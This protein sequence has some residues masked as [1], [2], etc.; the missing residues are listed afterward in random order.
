MDSDAFE[1][2]GSTSP[3]QRV[4]K[5][6]P[7][8]EGYRIVGVLG[9]GGM[10]IVYRAVQSRLNRVV[11]LKV[12]PAIVSTANPLAATRFR[13]EATA[14]AR[15]HHTNIVPIYDYGESQDAYYYAM[16]LITGT[17]LNNLIRR[18][19]EKNIAS[20]S[21]AQLMDVLRA[22]VAES[23]PEGT[24]LRRSGESSDDSF[25]AI[26]TSS[27]GRGR[28]YYHQ[29]AR[30]MADAADALHYA[31]DQGI[32]HRDIKP[33]N[34]ILSVDGRIMIADF[35]LARDTEGDS[36]TMT[37]ALLGTL[38]YISPE[39]AMAKRVRVDHRTD[40]YSLGATMY[41][42]LCFEPAFPGTEEKE[43]LGAIIAHDPTPPRKIASTVPQEL[44]TI[45][46]KTL[47]KSPAARYE[48]GRT[49]AEDL[50]RY[51]HDLPIVAT[52]PGTIKRTIK[53]ARRRKALVTA[54]SVSVLLS[55]TALF[56]VRAEAKR[57]EAEQQ[58]LAAR[59]RAFTD[60]GRYHV[61]RDEW[62]Q[63]QTAFRQAL[64]LDPDHIGTLV[65]FVWMKLEHFKQRP[66]LAG[67]EALEEVDEYCLRVLELDPDQL[68]ALNYHAVLLKKMGQYHEAIDVG[69]ELVE[70][71]PKHFWA[72]TNLGAYHALVGDL[73]AAEECLRRGAELTQTGNAGRPQDIANAWRNRASL[74]VLLG[75]PEAP[76]SLEA[77]IDANPHDITSWLLRVRLNL[78]GI[79]AKHA[80]AIPARRDSRTHHEGAAPSNN[81]RVTEALYDANY[82]DRLA[83][84][85]HPKA[86]RMRALAHLRGGELDQAIE[87][88]Y[89]ALKLEDMSTINHLV[90][91]IA[92]ARKHNPIIARDHLT[93]ALSTWP[94][95]LKEGEF[96]ATYDEGI[97]WFESAAELG[98]LRDEAQTLLGTDAP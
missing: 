73:A 41:E 24:D 32:T 71:Q 68:H 3:T 7:K 11:A 29:V 60:S 64:E 38:R 36:V 31:H 27:A 74:E 19:A 50:R 4:A 21:P 20:A 80:G 56:W 70:K 6:L 46:L 35:G 37:G 77:A 69:R 88:A 72:W 52:R 39:Q 15:L 42:L 14:A 28:P 89:I 1:I 54:I 17:P 45:C 90:L 8:I 13:R 55:A 25:S 23:P 48:T 65:N 83:N 86:K 49:L 16:E 44:E 34:L 26:A 47:E 87:Q 22:S 85:S 18:F 97:L 66:D 76:A 94:E 81:T 43:V 58:Q 98:Q 33:G 84:G 59:I 67:T 40:I 53:F 12:L 51:I 5:H 79:A 62:E 82:V 96:V 75:K 92:K 91:A 63:A 61:G 78:S 9:Q 95:A 30:W 57:S 10:G 2:P 93:A